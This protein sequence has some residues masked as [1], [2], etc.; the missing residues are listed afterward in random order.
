MNIIDALTSGSI[1]VLVVTVGKHFEAKIKKKIDSI[2]NSI[3][4]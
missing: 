1:I 3:F 2:T 4:P